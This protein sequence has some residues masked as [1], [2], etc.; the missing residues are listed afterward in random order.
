[1]LRRWFQSGWRSLTGIVALPGAPHAIALGAA[2]GTFI[3]FTPTLG[4]QLVLAAALAYLCRASAPAA[5]AA[6]WITNPLTAAPIY[7]ATYQLGSHLY[8][9]AN[10][11]TAL[12]LG[13]IVIGAIAALTTY[14]LILRAI[15]RRL[16]AA[17]PS[18]RAPNTHGFVSGR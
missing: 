8:P 12:S 18:L 10:P 6:V 9:H 4:L 2:I 3:A 16:T 13:G 14:S 11:V 1:M 17:S 15:T 7:A 5:L